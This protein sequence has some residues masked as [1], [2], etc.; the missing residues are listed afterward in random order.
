M[1]CKNCG[2]EIPDAAI[3]CAY[4]GTA[5]AST[6][7]PVAQPFQENS[8]VVDIMPARGGRRFVNFILDGI[9]LQ[10]INF[11]AGLF[12]GTF[13]M[14]IGY[15]L[16]WIL[17]GPLGYFTYFFL[18]ELLWSKSPAKF[19]SKTRVVNESGG[20]P[21][22]SQVAIRSLVRLIPFEPLSFLFMR[23][24]GRLVGWHDRWSHTLVI[25]EK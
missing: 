24:S 8:S 14:N 22:S 15:T 6:E 25:E 7:A 19:L 17:I 16:V 10:I 11:L 21:T 18:S 2:R 9:V 3:H 1:L 20:E 12:A 13:M 5:T 4:C 23:K